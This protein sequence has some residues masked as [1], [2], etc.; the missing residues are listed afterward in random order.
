MSEI[1]IL[2]RANDIVILG[3]MILRYTYFQDLRSKDQEISKN[4]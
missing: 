1:D 3:Q 4:E 2:S